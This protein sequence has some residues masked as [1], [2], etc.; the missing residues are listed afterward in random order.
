MD[1]RDLDDQ[2]DPV[3][4]RPGDA[5]EILVDRGLRAGA[6][7][8]GVA[9]P[10]A[11]AGIHRAD[12]HKF[13]RIGHGAL[14]ARNGD[15][16]VLERLAQHLERVA[17]EF[18]QLVEEQD[19]LVRERD[20]ARLRVGAAARERRGRD[21]VMRA[22]EGPCA[23]ERIVRGQQAHHGVDH[24]DLE[25]FLPRH[26]G[27]N[28]GQALGEHALAGARRPDEQDVVP[29]CGRDLE[30]AP[31]ILLSLHVAEIWQRQF[32]RFRLPFGRGSKGRLPA[33]MRGQLLNAAHAVDRQPV[34]QRGL[35]GI[36]RR[37]IQLPDAKFPR[38]HRHGQ[39]AAHRPELSLEA[40]LAQERA[41]PLRLTH[42]PGGNKNTQQNW[43]IIERTGLFLPSRRQID[44]DPAHGE[45][46]SAVFGGRPDALARL[47][48]SRV[49]QA[50]HVE[51]R[52]TVCDKALGQ[53]LIALDAR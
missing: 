36:F 34:R 24:R 51:A 46:E 33:E 45:L 22:A 42:R 27:Q 37:N 14:D 44:R 8:A 10:S 52:Q 39:H 9:V 16:A 15:L 4:K 5:A 31:G 12:Q 11:L 21:R 6:A 18:R 3:Q 43:Q 41:L 53:D 32:L 19:A 29:A 38:G 7:P 1:G 20:L 2:V 48:D 35:G 17:A 26:V 25:R 49:R 23:D 13:A 30:R 40:D 47:L 28:G 50:D